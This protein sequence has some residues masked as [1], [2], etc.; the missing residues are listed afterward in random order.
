MIKR[1]GI[2]CTVLAAIYLCA[3]FVQ[4][5]WW[6]PPLLSAYDRFVI[7]LFGVPIAGAAATCPWL[8]E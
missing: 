8:D 5:E 3:V 4:W 7:V 2:F 6:W 1:V